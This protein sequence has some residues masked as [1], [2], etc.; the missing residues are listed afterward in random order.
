MKKL[1]NL[2]YEL[3]ALSG[4][5]DPTLTGDHGRHH[6]R[7]EA[8]CAACPVAFYRQDGGRC[9]ALCTCSCHRFNRDDV[10]SH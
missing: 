3:R 10:P 8:N 9:V 2:H 7:G 1:G 4:E 6:S 5:C